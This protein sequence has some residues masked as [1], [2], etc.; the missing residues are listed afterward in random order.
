MRKVRTSVHLRA[1]FQALLVTFLW[2]TSWVFIKIGLKDIPALAFAGLRY[3]LAFLCLLPF[4]LRPAHRAALRDLTRWQWMQ[5]IALGL[6]F[7][8][9]TQGAMF[10]GLTYLP[11]VSASI[12]LNFTPVVVA[13]LG[14]L[15]LGEHPALL[16]WGG[17][18]MSV[19]G[20]L[21]YFYP[22]GLAA[23][24]P[25]G[26][27]VVAAGLLANAGAS[28]LG[29]RVNR[30]SDLPPSV[31]TAVSMGVGAV[32]LLIVGLSIQ[33]LPPLN[34]THWAI[35]AWLAVV[36]TA[37]AF[38]LWNHTLRTLPAME[39]S[40]INNT[41]LVQIAILAW[42]FL[43]EPLTAQGAVGLV[44]AGLGVLVVQLARRE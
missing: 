13:L 9:L 39:S 10:L 36:N 4:T 25:F 44:M 7:Y 30:A 40:L 15:L 5:L 24:D 34:L 35:I 21:V 38:T 27:V 22:G 3:A 37:F 11:A 29:R 23:G 6:M 2:S 32:V 42:L 12:I 16:Q 19:F 8:A 17:V 18:F 1:A 43:N 26:Y 28:I 14:I 31:V 20:A 33:G 41:M